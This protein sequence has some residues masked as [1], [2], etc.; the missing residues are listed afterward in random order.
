M[1]T[2]TAELEAMLAGAKID[3]DRAKGVLDALGE[4]A[5]R[6]DAALKARLDALLVEAAQ[7]KAGLGTVLAAFADLIGASPLRL[8][9]MPLAAAVTAEPMPA[10][11]PPPLPPVTAAERWPLLDRRSPPARR[12]DGPKVSAADAGDDLPQF[13]ARTGAA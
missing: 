7:R 2:L 8:P 13:L 12:L 5:A 4:A 6:H 1:Q 10:L 3:H 11:S 9:A